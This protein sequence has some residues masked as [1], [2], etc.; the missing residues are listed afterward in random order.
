MIISQPFHL[1]DHS[2]DLLQTVFS[3]LS[4]SFLHL[5]IFYFFFTLSVTASLDSSIILQSFLAY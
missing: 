3:L 5:R 1:S 4:R 2:W